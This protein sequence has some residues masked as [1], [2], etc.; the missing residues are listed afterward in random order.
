MNHDRQPGVASRVAAAQV[1]D[2]ILHR[3][4][5][6]K[7][8]MNTVL[9]KF[10]DVRD[11]A[12]V[13]AMVFAVVRQHARYADALEQWMSRPLAERDGVLRSLLYVG[14]AQ[15][16]AMKLPAHAALDATVE[17]VRHIQRPKHAGMVNALLRRAQR[18][19]IPGAPSLAW[20]AWLRERVAT[21]WPAQAES[22]FEQSALPAP[23]WLRVNADTMSVESLV[24]DLRVEGIDAQTDAELPQ[25]VRVAESIPVAR[26]PGF[27]NG[28]VTVQDGSAQHVALALTPAS[29]LRILD[30]C[31]APGGKAAHLHTLMPDAKL[32]ALDVDPRRVRRMQDSF[33]RMHLNIETRAA[34]ALD[35]ESWWDG[36]LFDVIVIDAPC[37]ATGI[38]RRQPDVLL[39]RR[40]HDLAELTVLQ[41]N[42]MDNLWRVLKPGG[43]MIYATCSILPEENEDQV[44]AFLS[45]TPDAQLRP[46]DHRF[47]HDTGAGSQRLTGERGMD[48]FFIARIEK[49]CR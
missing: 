9:P 47:G 39:H 3:G 45:G 11:R 44:S 46:L 30:A 35:V 14:F 12:L 19:G 24:D 41:A 42:L 33:E 29:G 5:S 32:L 8:A 6:L 13:E 17:A 23:L 10:K 43:V 36:A 34:N 20:P 22:I 1:A 21:A 15:L 2:Q 16:D 26:I 49:S 28:A 38:V 4:A 48:G 40:E 27:E 18:D 31:A 37:S 25:A 7:A